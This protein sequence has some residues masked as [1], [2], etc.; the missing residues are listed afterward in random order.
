MGSPKKD[1]GAKW[2]ARIAQRPI[3]HRKYLIFFSFWCEIHSK[4]ASQWEFLRLSSPRGPAPFSFL[5]KTIREFDVLIK[6]NYKI[7]DS[8]IL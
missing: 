6:I 4:H 7:A 2:F 1:L 5:V 3:Y 8:W